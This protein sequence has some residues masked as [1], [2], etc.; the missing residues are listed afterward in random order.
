MDDTDFKELL[1][2]VGPEIQKQDTCLRMAITAETKLTVIF[3][4]WYL[5][6]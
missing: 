5:I 4:W 3:T 6:G 1:E 2:L